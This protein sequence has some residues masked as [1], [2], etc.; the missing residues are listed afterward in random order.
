MIYFRNRKD[1]RVFAKKQEHYKVID[2]GTL[3]EMRWSVKVI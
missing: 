1:A 3:A 2:N